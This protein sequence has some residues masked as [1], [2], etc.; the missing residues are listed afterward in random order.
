MRQ[1]RH[2]LLETSVGFSRYAMLP[3]TYRAYA[4]YQKYREY[5]RIAQFWGKKWTK[6]PCFLSLI[7]GGLQP[8]GAPEMYQ[9]D[10][11]RS[12]E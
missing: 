3:V 10:P 9:A 5:C 12:T 8:P 7:P 2:N 11:C 6:T 1:Y 4:G